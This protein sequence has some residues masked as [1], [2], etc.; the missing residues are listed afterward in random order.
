[1]FY[2]STSPL[3]IKRF[4][5]RLSLEE[6]HMLLDSKR[7]PFWAPRPCRASAHVFT[8]RIK[9]LRA[10]SSWRVQTYQD[11]MKGRENYYW[12]NANR[13]SSL[14]MNRIFYWKRIHSYRWTEPTCCYWWKSSHWKKWYKQAKNP[15]NLLDPAKKGTNGIWGR[16]FSNDYQTSKGLSLLKSRCGSQNSH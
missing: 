9:P 4:A 12:K 16:K 13:Y 14:L 6:G 3:R 5:E 8:K 11:K 7:M 2:C 10:L 15:T 1:M